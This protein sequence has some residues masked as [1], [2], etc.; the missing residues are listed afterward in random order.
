MD[1]EWQQMLTV[2]DTASSFSQ[3]LDRMESQISPSQTPSLG[4]RRSLIKMVGGESMQRP[5]GR[6]NDLIKR[7]EGWLG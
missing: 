4:S 1:D 7:T 6:F 2:S 3:K 5:A